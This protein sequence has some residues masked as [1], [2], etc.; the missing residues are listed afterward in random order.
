MKPAPFRYHAPTTIDEGLAL[1]AEYQDVAKIM[2]GGQSLGP[3]L[4]MRLARPDVIID[5]SRMEDLQKTKISL[6]GCSYGAAVVHSSFE[7]SLVPDPTRGLLAMAASGIG[8][9]AIRNR[10]TIGGSMA[11]ADSS[12]E[13]PIVLAALDAKLVCRS[14]LRTRV[15]PS[16]EFIHGFFASALRD[17]ELLTEVQIPTLASGARW[18]IHKTS[19]KPGEFAESIAVAIV[20]ITDRLITSVEAW[21][22]GVGDSPLRVHTLN[23]SLSGRPLDDL[24]RTDVLAAVADAVPKSKTD[25]QRYDVQLHGITLWRAISQVKGTT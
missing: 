6:D 4:N 21:L 10:G 14:V 9:R 23:D 25:N 3:M 11:H 13:W 2:A 18:G 5:V 20:T 15:V 22:G 8:Y 7:D 24:T 12:A 1:L 16:R 17:D 19:R